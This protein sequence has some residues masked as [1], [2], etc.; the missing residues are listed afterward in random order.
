[1]THW[2]KCIEQLRTHIQELEGER[3]GSRECTQIVSGVNAKLERR[4]KEVTDLLRRCMDDEDHC[5]DGSGFS[6]CERCKALGGAL[7]GICSTVKRERAESTLAAVRTGLDA[8]INYANGR[9]SEWGDRA[10]TVLSM[11]ETVQELLRTTAP[12]TGEEG[13]DGQ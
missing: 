11:L 1:M 6:Y 4:L 12:A 13:P 10:E 8:A 7:C 3:D 2:E 5:E 9:W